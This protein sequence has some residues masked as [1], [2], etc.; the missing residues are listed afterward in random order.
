MAAK[1]LRYRPDFP[2]TDNGHF[3]IWEQNRFQQ[4]KHEK[5]LIG[6]K[7]FLKQNL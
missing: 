7:T 1:F 5:G 3:Q 2:S 6:F 4:I